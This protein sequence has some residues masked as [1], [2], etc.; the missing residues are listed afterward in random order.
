MAPFFLPVCQSGEA[1]ARLCD[2]PVCLPVCPSGVAA[3]YQL[4]LPWS[5]QLPFRHGPAHAVRLTSLGLGS[6]EHGARSLA[7]DTLSCVQ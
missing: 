5:L 3:G 4:L 7:V 1:S 6:T 2:L